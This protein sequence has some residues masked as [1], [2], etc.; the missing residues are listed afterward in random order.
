[1]LSDLIGWV[2][3]RQGEGGVEEQRLDILFVL[4]SE[5]C[6]ASGLSL[7]NRRQTQQSFKTPRLGRA[8]SSARYTKLFNPQLGS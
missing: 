5:G 4:G 3:A 1:M 2:N 7:C 8:L 6:F